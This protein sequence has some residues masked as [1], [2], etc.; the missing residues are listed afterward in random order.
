MKAIHHANE[1]PG[2]EIEK[3]FLVEGLEN[4]GAFFELTETVFENLESK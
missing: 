4:D 1:H 3:K 2:Y